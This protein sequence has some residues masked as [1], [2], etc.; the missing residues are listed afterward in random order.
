[1][2]D[3]L[4]EVLT[5]DDVELGCIATSMDGAITLAGQMLVDRGAVNIGYVQ[6]MRDREKTVSTYLGNGVALPHGTLETKGEVLSTRLVVTQ[7]PEG[8]EWDGGTAHLVVGL[9]AIGDDHVAVLSQ[10]AEVLQDEDLCHKLWVTTDKQFLLD[11][12]LAPGG[13]DEDEDE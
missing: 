5:A 2:E 6:G 9:A 1:M 11:Q 13:D 4:A 3:G 10:L 8:V 12:L 7:Y